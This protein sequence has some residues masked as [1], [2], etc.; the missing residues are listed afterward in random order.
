MSHNISTLI[1]DME[2]LKSDVESLKN[3]TITEW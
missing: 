2:I 3:A 1:A